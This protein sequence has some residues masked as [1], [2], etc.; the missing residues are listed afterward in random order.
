MRWID[1]EVLTKRGCG[2]KSSSPP[3]GVLA[4]QNRI[5]RHSAQEQLPGW[6]E[7]PVGVDCVQRAGAR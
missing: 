2:K 4:G 6:S 3:S 1:L 7:A 5:L